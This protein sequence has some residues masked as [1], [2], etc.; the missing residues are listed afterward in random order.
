MSFTKEIIEKAET[1]VYNFIANGYK[2]QSNIPGNKVY[3]TDITTSTL[4]Y[5]KNNIVIE[6]YLMHPNSNISMPAIHG[7]PFGNQ[8][9][10][11]EGDLAAYIQSPDGEI[12][13]RLFGNMQKNNTADY[14]NYGIYGIPTKP[15]FPP[16]NHGFVAGE[17]G[18]IMYVI[19]IWDTDVINPKSASV[20]YE[21]QP[22][23]SMHKD[24][25]LK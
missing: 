8:A 18:A 17:R 5:H 9:V 11:V 12:Y 20:I 23:G 10:I 15:H 14:F 16:Y 24:Q 6:Y 3:L 25:L 19:Q 21:G 1:V 2:H 4:V 22:L 13:C 7:H